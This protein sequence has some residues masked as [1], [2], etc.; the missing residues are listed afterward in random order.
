MP[1]LPVFIKRGDSRGEVD[2]LI[3][4]LGNPGSHLKATCGVDPYHYGRYLLR[5]AATR[6]ED[7]RLERAPAP[8]PFVLSKRDVTYGDCG[9]IGYTYDLGSRK[10]S[11]HEGDDHAIDIRLEGERYAWKHWMRQCL[12]FAYGPDLLRSHKPLCER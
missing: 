6:S 9:R 10:L 11:F 3:R 7:D 4:E 8:E 1:G 5:V 12:P 2:A